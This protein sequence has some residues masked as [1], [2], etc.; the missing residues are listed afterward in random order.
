MAA[1]SWRHVLAAAYWM[2]DVP[3]L[4][5]V[6]RMNESLRELAHARTPATHASQQRPQAEPVTMLAG[7]RPAVE[8]KVIS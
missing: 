2:L 3:G 4:D 7:T 8:R 5:G 1:T 6:D